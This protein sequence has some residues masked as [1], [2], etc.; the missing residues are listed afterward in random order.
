MPKGH[1]F[2]IAG[3]CVFFLGGKLNYTLAFCNSAVAAKILSAISPTINFEVGHIKKLPIIY[4]ENSRQIDSI[5]N[6]NIALSREDW[7]SF[8]TSWDFRRHPLACCVNGGISDNRLIRD[9]YKRWERECGGRFLALKSNEEKLNR[10]FIDIYGLQSE[11]SPEVDDS[12]VTVRRADPGREIR[13]L[14]SYAVG[15]MFGRY[16]LDVPGLVY[17]GGDWDAGKYGGFI[18]VS[19]NIVIITDEEYLPD[20]D[21]VARFV[22]FIRIVYGAG[23]LEE[24]LRYIA[25]ALGVRG[26]TAREKIR[27]YFTR[28]FFKDHVKTYQKRPIYWL[29]DSGKA[30]GFKAL[31]YIHRYDRDIIGKLRVD[32]LQII[33]GVYE[34]EI[35]RIRGAIETPGN[36]RGGSDAAAKRYEKLVGQLE[37]INGYD[38]KLARLALARTELDL[39]DG[40]KVNYEKLQRDGDGNEYEV[41][42]KI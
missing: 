40:V 24:N 10:I 5:V 38:K 35:N 20:N 31:I 42:G 22:E 23:T 7:D 27:N 3:C 6:K 4:E 14:I 21:I 32:Y 25:G 28:D 2:D 12:E 8:E 29:F 33:Q 36:A 9:C 13:G 30:G 17:A 11:L 37:E 16:S 34:N 41:L 1:L 39:D 18:P 19:D 15:C 26:G